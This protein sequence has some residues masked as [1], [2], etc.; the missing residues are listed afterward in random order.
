MKD[1]FS[2]QKPAPIY[3]LIVMLVL[4][5]MPLPGNA[6]LS[7]A[8]GTDF[9][10]TAPMKVTGK[11]VD[12]TGTPMVGVSV[13][14]PG[15][16]LGTVTD[17]NGN[18]TI[19]LPEGQNHLSFSFIGYITQLVSVNSPIHNISMQPDLKSLDE[20]VVIGYGT[21]TK[22][23]LT[24]SITSVG[25]KDFNEGLVS[26]PE[27]L[28]NGK[29]AGV[30]IV[31][32]SGS[33]TAGSTIRIR[34][35]ASLNASND[36][37][38][39]LDGV[40]LETGGI[41]GNSN[42]FLSLINP[43]DIENMTILKDAS[44]TAIYGSRASNGVIIITTKKGS[45]T[46]KVNVSSTQSIQH[47]MEVADI[48]SPNEFR[49]VINSEGTAA[50]QA[51]LGNE[52]TDWNDKIF[53][54]ALGTDNNISISGNL[55]KKL[56]FRLSLGYFNQ[57]GILKTDNAERVT[58]NL[59]LSPSFFDDHLK[60]NLNMKGTL[61]NNRFAYTDAIY[62]AAAYNPTIG[63][64]SGNTDF[65]GYN[66]ALGSDGTPT[67]SGQV[68]NPVGLLMQYH[69]TS[70]VSRVI[71]NF[72]I[73]YK[74]H[75]L[76]ELRTHLTLGY[77]YAK[78]KG[79]IYVPETAALYYS[80]GGRDYSYGPEKDSNKL[81]T[82][83]L[84]YSKNIDP[85]NSRI[86]FTAG[87]DYQK[88]IAKTN[89]YNVLNVAG[90]SQ[91]STAAKDERHVLLSYYGRLNYT[92]DS[93]YLLTATLRR[94]GS[95]RFSQDNRWGLFPSV[96]LA[97]HLS[98][99][100]FLKR[101]SLLSNLK[102]RLSYGV[103]G[104]QD[105]IGNYSYMPSYTISQDGAQY[106]LGDTYYYTYRAESYVS[107]LKWETTDAYNAG[108]DFGFFKNRISGSIDYYNRHTHD[109]LATVP[110]AAGT[111]FDETVT[112]NVGS[113]KS[114]GLEFTINGTPL[115]NKNWTWNISYNLT[116]EKVKITNLSLSEGEESTFMYAGQS[117]DDYYLQIMKAGYAPYTFYTYHQV[118]N[119]EGKPIEG[120]Y[121]DINGDNQI[122]SSDLYCGKSPNPD[123]LMGLSS[124]LRFKEWTLGC[125]LRAS[126]GNYAYNGT[127]M[128]TGALGTVSYN[129]Y[130]LNN[131]SRSYLKTGFE[132]R[133]YLSDYY[134]ENA[135]F[136]KMD[137]ITLGYDLGEIFP[138]CKISVSGMIQN[139]FTITGYSGVDPEIY[140]GIESSFYPRARTYS[141][142]IGINL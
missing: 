28:I 113:M 62:A 75:F 93:K 82:F 24:G 58:G 34:G 42:N 96:A 90:E 26:S 79:W 55:K 115:S 60:L 57:D 56:P 25:S 51:L 44:S 50:Q 9:I 103:T 71:G 53:K 63:V 27:Q 101:F 129:S 100:D 64:Y 49:Q 126:I 23:D 111:N 46:L 135:S 94:D 131:L 124:Q 95:S 139:V 78:G 40:P 99:E 15:T 48:L 92:F 22:K 74:V 66:E 104:Q 120:M 108:L 69:S 72:D 97:W 3:Y 1:L 5:V 137:N 14:V 110:A 84:N 6:A 59:S 31:S 61:N 76:P 85:I 18:Y 138:Q 87:Y 21:Q 77:D 114:N 109:L 80:S 132:S 41:S 2:S 141:L 118:Y 116:W 32:N 7:P 112:T 65:G 128:N 140:G 81:L 88:W 123:F 33:P 52:N 125:S 10:N 30:Q 11:V 86:D 136:L 68:Y 17:V 37:L 106:L 98:D 121:A 39:V 12:E 122:T 134:I 107:D 45:G 20:V 8:N 133:Q 89:A 130:Q 67:I 43:S 16:T 119:E 73:D 102:L 13:V 36:P 47:R 105:G 83:Y 4:S 19:D 117:F 70:R 29:V 91:S 54:L 38:I 142:S 127:A 35:G